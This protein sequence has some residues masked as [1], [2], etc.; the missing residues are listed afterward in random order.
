MRRLY[1]QHRLLTEFP[2]S[3]ERIARYRLYPPLDKRS[4]QHQGD[5]PHHLT[6]VDRYLVRKHIMLRDPLPVSNLSEATKHPRMSRGRCR[7]DNPS[8][9]SIRILRPYRHSIRTVQHFSHNQ[10][11]RL[12]HQRWIS[13]QIRLRSPWLRWLR[14]V[15]H[16]QFLPIQRKSICSRCLAKHLFRKPPSNFSRLRLQWG[17][18]QLS[19]K[20]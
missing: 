2:V 4:L 20:P 13:S 16:L 5:N 10:A 14:L 7:A 11:R 15:P 3:I 9:L 19:G 6:T 17:L 1:H 12:R 8:N 18:S